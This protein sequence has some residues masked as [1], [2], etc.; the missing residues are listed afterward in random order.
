MG[1][2]AMRTVHRAAVTAEVGLRNLENEE[3][4]MKKIWIEDQTKWK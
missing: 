2:R 1:Q 4:K 3:Q